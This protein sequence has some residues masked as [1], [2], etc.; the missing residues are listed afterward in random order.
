[1]KTLFRF[2]LLFFS[3]V[4]Y[5]QDPIPPTFMEA[6]PIWHHYMQNK[7]VIKNQPSDFINN[8]NSVFPVTNFL[9]KDSF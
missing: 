4:V 5:G 9:L 1:M 7:N 2:I 8:N 3:V 6:N